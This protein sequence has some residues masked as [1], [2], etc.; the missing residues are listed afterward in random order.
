MHPFS[1]LLSFP[2]SSPFLSPLLSSLLSFTLLPST[3]FLLLLFLP[4]SRGKGDYYRLGHSDD[5]H[6]RSPKRVVG[7]LANKKVVDIAC[8]SLHCVVCTEDGKL[9]TWGD[10][11]EGQIGNDSTTAM[12]GPQV[13]TCHNGSYIQSLYTV[14]IYSH[15]IQSLYPL[16]SA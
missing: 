11:D 5:S 8:G 13:G 12:Q 6:C 9:F 14:T 1:P 10:N 4:F 7:P 2:L 3:P 15:Y 16:K